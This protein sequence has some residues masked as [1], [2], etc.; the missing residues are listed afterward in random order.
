MPARLKTEIWASALIRRCQGEGV[1]ASVA[2]K[3]DTDAGAVLIKIYH[4]NGLARLYTQMRMADGEAAWR[5]VFGGVKAEY[6]IDARIAREAEIDPDL[7]EIEIEDPA[8]E[9]FLTERILDEND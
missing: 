5:P 8:G 7:W 4:R 3:G 6:E 1:Y 9:R 2:R